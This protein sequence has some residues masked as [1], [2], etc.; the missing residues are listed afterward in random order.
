LILP[1]YARL[2]AI[3]KLPSFSIEERSIHDY[4]HPMD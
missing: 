3:K 4:P 2:K 1:F